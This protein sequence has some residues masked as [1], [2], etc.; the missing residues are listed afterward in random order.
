MAGAWPRQ[1]IT[2]VATSSY[3]SDS[4]NDFIL[5][6]S[7]RIDRRRSGE[8]MRV[9]TRYTSYSRIVSRS[10]LSP[11]DGPS[12][13]FRSAPVGTTAAPGSSGNSVLDCFDR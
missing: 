4:P 1:G 5:F 6:G 9:K 3:S 11:G 13:R 2:A 10:G 7:G 8:I 12:D